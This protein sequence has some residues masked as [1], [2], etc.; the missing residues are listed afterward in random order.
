MLIIINLYGTYRGFLRIREDEHDCII[1]SRG[2]PDNARIFLITDHRKPPI[3]LAEGSPITFSAREVS[4]AL[5]AQR[6]DNA[7][8]I[9]MQG[10]LRGQPKISDAEKRALWTGLNRAESE[11]KEPAPPPKE[12]S[13]ALKSILS[14]AEVLFSENHG[15]RSEAPIQDTGGKPAQKGPRVFNPF[16]RTYPD[17]VWQQ[18]RYRNTILLEGTARIADERLHIQAIPASFFPNDRTAERMGFAKL[19]Y[20]DGGRSYRLRVRYIPKQKRP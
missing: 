2:I 8:N 17:S 7:W 14:E 5:V 10:S 18:R 1:D 20:D 6:I 16:S 19:A 4:G 3:E 13:E 12:P 11:K 15:K 9:I